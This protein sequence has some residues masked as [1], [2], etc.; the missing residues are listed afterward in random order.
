MKLVQCQMLGVRKG[1]EMAAQ[2]EKYLVFLHLHV[3]LATQWQAG[4]KLGQLS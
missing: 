3:F 2:Q 4:D 1:D